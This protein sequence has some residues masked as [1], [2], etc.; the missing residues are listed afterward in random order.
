[1]TLQYDMRM[2]GLT[3]NYGETIQPTK[4]LVITI[5]VIEATS[6][7]IVRKREGIMPQSPP[8]QTTS[9]PLD[10][11]SVIQPKKLFS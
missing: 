9:L 11:T 2:D 4:S 10:L 1:M 6:N 8:Q 3:K 7:L 5:V